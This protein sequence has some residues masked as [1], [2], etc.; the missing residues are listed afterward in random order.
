MTGEWAAQGY[1]KFTKRNTPYVLQTLDRGQMVILPAGQLKTVY[2]LPEDQLDVFGTLQDQIQAKYTVGD[3][4]VIR[5]P[6]HRYLIPSQLTRDLGPFT[7]SM[8]DEIEDEITS[9]WGV[10]A[11]WKE[12]SV[13]QVCFRAVSRASNAALY[14]SPLCR[15]KAYL[16]LLEGQTTALFGGSLFI[17]MMP[18]SVRPVIGYLVHLWCAYYSRKIAK[19]CEPYIEK[20]LR[21]STEITQVKS[22]DKPIKDG[23]QLVIDEAHARNDPTQLSTR[24]ISD[25]L[26]IA[27]NVTLNGVTFTAH[28]LIL[29]LISSNP[30]LGYIEAL[31]DECRHSLQAAGGTW[32]LAAI[33]SLK[34]L[35]SAIRESMRFAPFSSIAM[36]RTVVSPEGILVEHGKTPIT[37]LRNT[38]LALPVERIHRDEDFYSSP[39]EFKPF[40]FVD[41]NR[42]HSDDGHRS[43]TTT[44]AATTVDDHFFG[45]GTS[46]HPCP[47]R[48]IAVHE[49]KLIMAHILLN[50]D[51]EY[52]DAEL[53]FTNLLAM[54]VPNMDVKIRVRRRA[55]ETI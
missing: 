37:I 50:Y 13:W 15:D 46:K 28:H 6:Y 2:K 47:G 34:L 54:K 20:R 3:Q 38:V 29:C 14:G 25:R 45:F 19:I 21:E 41:T 8:F 49:V 51:L 10:D 42:H 12:V 43:Y 22:A 17:S 4:R 32:D 44:S 35:D 9:S 24:L 16:Q 1:A 18:T 31:R 52:T 23:L 53:Q 7:S 48:F 39:H 40:R 30:S 5:D 27:N 11:D 55:T 33:R 36:A 26:L